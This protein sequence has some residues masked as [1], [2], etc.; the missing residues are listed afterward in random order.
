MYKK[1]ILLLSVI[2]LNIP[3]YGQKTTAEKQFSVTSEYRQAETVSPRQCT[4]VSETEIS[5]DSRVSNVNYYEN[6][7]VSGREVSIQNQNNDGLTLSPTREKQPA[8]ASR[9]EKTSHSY[10]RNKNK[11]I[12]GS[13]NAVLLNAHY[14]TYPL[15]AV[16]KENS[17]IS[18]KHT[19]YN[20]SCKPVKPIGYGVYVAT[21]SNLEKVIEDAGKYTLMLKKRTFFLV[22]VTRKPYQYY[23][24]IG[25]FSLSTPAYKLR[26]ELW[27][28]FPCCFVI[29]YKNSDF[30]G[31]PEPLNDSFLLIQ[32]SRSPH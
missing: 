15:S 28:Y 10:V 5:S 26:N 7:S 20:S 17:E 6:P 8:E 22:D 3:L 12:V 30:N 29:S 9:A 24:I 18:D 21:Y 19:V 13:K 2:V 14:C 1:H 4:P 31:M 11:G 23:L 27:K 16:K 25:K 32:K